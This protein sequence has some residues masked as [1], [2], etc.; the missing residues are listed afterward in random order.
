MRLKSLGWKMLF[1][2]SSRKKVEDNVMQKAEAIVHVWKP[3]EYKIGGLNQ[4]RQEQEIS[5][6]GRFL[7]PM[8]NFDLLTPVIN[9]FV[10][11]WRRSVGHATL[12]V[13]LGNRKPLYLS[14]WPEEDDSV[15]ILKSAFGSKLKVGSKKMKGFFMQSL[16]EDIFYMDSPPKELTFEGYK[17]L[18]RNQNPLEWSNIPAPYRNIGFEPES[19]RVFL[20]DGDAVYKYVDDLLKTPNDYNLFTQNCSTFVAEALKEGSRSI[21]SGALVGVKE[22]YK[23]SEEALKLVGIIGQIF[24]GQR[25]EA[26]QAV[27]SLGFSLPTSISSLIEMQGETPNSVQ[28]YAER[29]QKLTTS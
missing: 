18:L 17:S 24:Q 26:A 5:A 2:C 19:I 13:R 14:F 7:E 10:G 27:Y 8:G 29:L 4:I 21:K 12:S 9:S 25:K 22:S 1:H 6:H 3:M 28:R 16:E 23:R 20:P 11:E 15:N